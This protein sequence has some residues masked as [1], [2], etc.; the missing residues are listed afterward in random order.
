MWKLVL[1]GTVALVM[2]GSTVALAQPRAGGPERPRW[3]PSEADIAA[4]A[5]AR[6]AALRAGLVL[7]PEQEKHWPAFEAALN[8]LARYRR[9][10]RA[11][12]QAEQPAGNPTE[13][14]RRYSDAL[15]GYGAVLRK[16]ADVQEALYNSL[17]EAQKR[18]FVILSQLMRGGS[19]RH[20]R[21]EGPSE[22]DRRS[23]TGEGGRL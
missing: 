21:G 7:T 15:T 14:L 6:I 2:A 11:A 19:S 9:E 16:V 1:A 3:Q 13:R 17:D 10:R 4:F 8:D 18:R 22:G 5:A 20:H 23:T 12:R